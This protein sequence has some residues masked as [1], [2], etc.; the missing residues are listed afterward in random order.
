MPSKARTWPWHAEQPSP[1]RASPPSSGRKTTWWVMVNNHSVWRRAAHSK[2]WNSHVH[3]DMTRRLNSNCVTC[4]CQNK[5]QIKAPSLLEADANKK[6]W[7]WMRGFKLIPQPFRNV[8]NLETGCQLRL[9]KV[10]ASVGWLFRVGHLVV[11]VMSS[12]SFSTLLANHHLLLKRTFINTTDLIT[13]QTY[14]YSKPLS[15]QQIFINTTDFI[16]TTDLICTTDL[17]QYNRFL[18]VQ[19]IFISTSDIRTT[20]LYQ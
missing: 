7:L 4:L 1:G 8:V 9:L 2:M 15:V 17:Y 14:Q 16:S 18:S 3:S 6:R 11:T 20:G 12:S 13:Q 10:F 5:T 19:Q